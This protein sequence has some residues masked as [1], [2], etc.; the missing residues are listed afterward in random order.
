MI[1]SD[2]NYRVSPTHGMAVR[3]CSLSYMPARTAANVLK[4][5]RSYARR[6][7]IVQNSRRRPDGCCE[8]VTARRRC[9]DRGSGRVSGGGENRAVPRPV[10]GEGP[11]R[12]RLGLRSEMDGY[13][14]AVHVEPGQVR[15]ITRGGHDWTTRFP[16]I[17]HDARE[18]RLDSA[19]LTARRLFWTSAGHPPS[20]PCRRRL[21]AEAGS[22]PLP[23]TA[24]RL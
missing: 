16:T 3:Q 11:R 20:A 17:V 2:A 15:V 24:L 4:A 23:G 13:R 19:S 18:L 12:R 10:G 14:L 22:D 7:R 8:R 5:R 6:M 1:D 9:V 21:A